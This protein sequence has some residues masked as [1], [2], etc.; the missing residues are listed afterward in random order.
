MRLGFPR[1]LRRPT[2]EYGAMILMMFLLVMFRPL[3]MMTGRLMFSA[4]EDSWTSRPLGV[5]AGMRW[6]PRSFLEKAEAQLPR[7]SALV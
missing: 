6:S 3:L 7:P 2:I 1:L 5:A 4:T